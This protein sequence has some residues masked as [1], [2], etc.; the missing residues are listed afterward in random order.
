MNKENY[1]KADKA[2]QLENLNTIMDKMIELMEEKSIMPEDFKH[3]EFFDNTGK[4]ECY[5]IEAPNDERAI[6]VIKDP[7]FYSFQLFVG[8]TPVDFYI[9]EAVKRLYDYIDNFVKGNK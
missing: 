6:L 9:D 7:K 5:T 8:M 4:H 3:S 1:E 2:C